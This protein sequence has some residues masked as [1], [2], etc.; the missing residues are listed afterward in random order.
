MVIVLQI[1]H[2][3]PA[4]ACIMK[5]FLYVMYVPLGIFALLCAPWSPFTWFSETRW[6][7]YLVIPVRFYSHILVIGSGWLLII[8]GLVTFLKAYLEIRRGEGGLVTTGVYSVVRHPQYLGIMLLTLGLTIRIMRAIA[9]IAWFTLVF[10]YLLL[11]SSED[12]QLQE[13]F[14]EKY[15]GYKR[16]VPFVLPLIPPKLFGWLNKILP[17]K[18]W[19]RLVFSLGTYLLIVVLLMVILKSI[20]P[21]LPSRISPCNHLQN[22]TI[23]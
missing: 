18:K 4:I 11:A 19:K 23:A 7:V 15:P 10:G 8:V 12:G 22:S 1:F 13:E 6:L 3:L 16:R 20:M 14:R 21:S 9:F 2:S 17:A 5:P